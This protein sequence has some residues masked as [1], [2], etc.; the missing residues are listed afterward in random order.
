MDFK[1]EALD[2]N[3][4]PTGGNI[5]A[6]SQDQAIGMLQRRGLTIT[7]FA[8]EGGGEFCNHWGPSQSLTGY[9]TAISCFSHVR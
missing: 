7:S 4:K 9:Q 2:Q 1:Y 3:G 6:A 5:S 8:A